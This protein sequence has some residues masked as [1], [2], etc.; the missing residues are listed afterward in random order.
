[1]NWF[2]AISSDGPLILSRL[3]PSRAGTHELDMNSLVTLHIAQGQLNEAV[4]LL[5]L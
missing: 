1:M 4:L 5:K 3:S 2:V